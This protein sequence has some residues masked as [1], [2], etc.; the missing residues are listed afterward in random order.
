MNTHFMRRLNL[1]CVISMA[2]SHLSTCAVA[3]TGP[4]TYAEIGNQL[5]SAQGMVEQQKPLTDEE[6]EEREKE[7][8]LDVVHLSK[9]DKQRAVF[10]LPEPVHNAQDTT[11]E[12]D[13]IHQANRLLIN[14]LELYCSRDE[15]N[16]G[17]SLFSKIDMTTTVFGQKELAKLLASPTAN[18][19]KLQARQAIV[20]EL[21]KNDELFYELEAALIKIRNAESHIFSYWQAPNKATSEL[22]NS[23]YFSVLPQDFNRYACIHEVGTRLGNLLTAW[24]ATGDV[25]VGAAIDYILINQMQFGLFKSMQAI[26]H[27]SSSDTSFSSLLYHKAKD[28]YLPFVGY[29]RAKQLYNNG[30]ETF[31]VLGFDLSSQQAASVAT[32]LA[33]VNTMNLIIKFWT[34]KNAI[35]Q[36]K[37]TNNATNYLQNRLIGAATL[38]TTTARMQQFCKKNPDITEALES[39]PATATLLRQLKDDSSDFASLVSMLQTNTFKGS[40]SFFSYTGRVLAAHK[41]MEKNKSKFNQ[42][43]RFIG[44]IDALLSIA[45]LYKKFKNERVTYCFVNYE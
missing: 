24:Q 13:Y 22:V 1:L 38:V 26:M 5:L 9:V 12:Q 43:M 29:F 4:I 36:A 15:Q 25:V 17:N 16:R 40:A 18:I 45:K 10:N 7:V 30:Q 35:S 28:A 41:L 14:D 2:L 39:Y 3:A 20:K 42:F 34:L 44:E 8:K 11:P 37:M 23:L 33:T 32:S 6:K 19:K 27:G 21:I 31:N